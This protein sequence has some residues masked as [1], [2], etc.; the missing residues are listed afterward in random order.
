MAKKKKKK[1]NKKTSKVKTWKQK[2]RMRKKQKK[3]DLHRFR[4]ERRH[5]QEGPLA[6][7]VAVVAGEPGSGAARQGRHHTDFSVV[8]ALEHDPCR[9]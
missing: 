8:V 6:I 5:Q 9:A 1:K 4:R 3:K 2:E 7:P